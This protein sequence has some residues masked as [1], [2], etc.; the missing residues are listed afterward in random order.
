MDPAS[1][2][3]YVVVITASGAL[4]PGPLTIA[5]VIHGAGG[6]LKAGLKCAVGHTIVEFPLILFI[7]LGLLTLTNQGF[8]RFLEVVGGLAL[9]GFGLIQLHGSLRS[10]YGLKGSGIPTGGSPLLTGIMLSG[11]NPYFL[12]WWFSV[13]STLVYEAL[14]LG[15]LQGLTLMYL[16]HVWVDYAWL[17][18][19]SHL[20]KRG[21]KVLGLKVY[22]Y[23]L[24]LFSLALMGFGVFWISSALTS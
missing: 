13:G 5:T 10:D 21:R 18:L 3:A 9:V 1:F 4:S 19:I 14:A 23:V 2:I 7:G 6:G 8:K 20:S 16:A 24:A 11:L 12:L 22:G 17:A 15:F